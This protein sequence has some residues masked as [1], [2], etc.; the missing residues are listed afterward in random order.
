MHLP[1][2]H[3]HSPSGAP[4][5]TQGGRRTHLRA[6]AIVLVFAGELLALEPVQHLADSFR[7]LGKHGLERH[8]WGELTSLLDLVDAELL[9]QLERVN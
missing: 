8:A 3:H 1:R 7:W 5:S 9:G 6:L 4:Q 2:P